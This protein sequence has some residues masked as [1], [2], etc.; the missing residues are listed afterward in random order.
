[1]LE[2]SM[3]KL[4]LSKVFQEWLKLLIILCLTTSNNGLPL[5]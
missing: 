1:M 4:L 2:E 5:V 3:I